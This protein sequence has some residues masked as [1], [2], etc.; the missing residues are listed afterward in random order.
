MLKKFVNNFEANQDIAM[1]FIQ[2]F[3]WY[4]RTEM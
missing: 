2:K 3:I 1:P 4:A